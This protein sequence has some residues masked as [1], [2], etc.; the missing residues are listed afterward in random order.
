MSLHRNNLL[1]PS[2]RMQSARR[3]E[4]A[5][6]FKPQNALD[7]PDVKGLSIANSVRQKYHAMVSKF[8]Q[9]HITSLRHE[10]KLS[11]MDANLEEK[12]SL[13]QI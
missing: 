1:V 4:P 9:Q 6:R 5:S 2:S 11:N 3:G 12:K 10:K 8:S 7:G 13:Q